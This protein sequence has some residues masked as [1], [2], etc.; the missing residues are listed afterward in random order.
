MEWHMGIISI[1]EI[2]DRAIAATS[3]LFYNK[4]IVLKKFMD[5][6]LPEI[7]GDADK[8]IQ[9]VVNLISNAVK[10]TK[11]GEIVCRVV[12]QGDEIITSIKDSGIGIAKQDHE[13][14][15]EQ[16]KQVGGDT[17][18]DKPKGTGLGLPICREIIEHHGGRIWLESEQGKGST[19]FFALPINQKDGVNKKIHLDDL[20]KQLKDHVAQSGFRLKNGTA[21]ILIVDDDDSIRSLLRQE[22]TDGGYLIEEAKNGKDALESVRNH[23][24][25]LII[26][27]VMMPEMNGFEVASILKNDPKTQDIPII[28]LSVVQD[29]ARGYRIGVDRYLTKPIDTNQLFT[30]V[31]VLLEQGKSRKKVMIVDEDQAAVKT[32]TDVLQTKGYQVF[33]S[34]WHVLAE[35]AVA[36]QP[37]MIILNSVFS[38][39]QE[40]VQTL[41]FEKGLENV[42]FLIYE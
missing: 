33:E 39:R 26:L 20:V 41:R 42:L 37:D 16:F 2:V 6:G 7:S 17:L 28:I 36:T 9:V 23:Q 22:L 12:H 13:A 5:T 24:P 34:D 18:T 27:D 14:V 40:V 8:I 15:F 19:F 4:N 21:T 31:G 25:D 29:K 30:E 11:E 35:K 10:F 3:S 1:P 32:L 38:G